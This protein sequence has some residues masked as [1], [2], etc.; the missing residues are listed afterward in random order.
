MFRVF[1][2]LCFVAFALSQEDDVPQTEQ[3]DMDAKGKIYMSVFYKK[4]LGFNLFVFA[5]RL[6]HDMCAFYILQICS[7]IT[8]GGVLNGEL[9]TQRF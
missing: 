1:G 3:A 2:I 6:F 9:Y 7:G 4:I 8:L 5:Y